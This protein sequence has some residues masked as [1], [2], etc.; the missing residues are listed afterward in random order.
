[1]RPNVCPCL[2][3]VETCLLPTCALS[4]M[5]CMKTRTGSRSLSKPIKATLMEYW[6]RLVRSKL[7]RTAVAA[8]CCS[9]RHRFSGLTTGQPLRFRNRHLLICLPQSQK[10]KKLLTK[11]R[12]TR[13]YLI[14]PTI[15]TMEE[16][17]STTVSVAEQVWQP[18]VMI[19]ILVMTTGEKMMAWAILEMMIWVKLLSRT[20]AWMLWLTTLVF[21][22]RLLDALLQHAGS[23]T[24]LTL[25]I[26][27]Q[28]GL[29]RLLFSC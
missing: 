27:L 5:A 24:H 11:R 3:P 22:C 4:F 16:T 19:L 29:C 26:M 21:K 7:L 12:S 8:V 1:M 13:L 17:N 9:P 6:K 2:K 14:W 20:M 15:G 25:P 18:P 10:K 23:R 28:Q